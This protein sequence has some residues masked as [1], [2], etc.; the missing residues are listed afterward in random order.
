MSGSQWWT[1]A[2]GAV[3]GI[4]VIAVFLLAFFIVI[5]IVA[6]LRKLRRQGR[7]GARSLDEL[8]GDA[9]S[10]RMMPG[11]SPRGPVDQ[12]RSPELQELAERNSS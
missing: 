2:A 5:T 4:T 3:Q 8:V 6:D 11:D 12:L 10:V 7:N 9:A 1:L